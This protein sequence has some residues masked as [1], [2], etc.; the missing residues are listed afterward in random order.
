M[1]KVSKSV[2]GMINN[3]AASVQQCVQ[4]TRVIFIAPSQDQSSLSNV[5]YVRNII[6]CIIVLRTVVVKRSN[7]SR[8]VNRFALNPSVH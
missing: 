4:R 8:L 5:P 3:V 6:L 1:F 2:V 7:L